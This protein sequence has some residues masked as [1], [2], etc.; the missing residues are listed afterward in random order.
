MLESGGE[1]GLKDARGG[2]GMSLLEGTMKIRSSGKSEIK[3]T[4]V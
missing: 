3:H 4:A 2:G 1:D